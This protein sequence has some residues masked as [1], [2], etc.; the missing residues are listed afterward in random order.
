MGVYNIMPSVWSDSIFVLSGRAIHRIHAVRRQQVERQ[1]AFALQG[2]D[3]DYPEHF[4]G[5]QTLQRR[6]W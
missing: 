3:Q 4:P 1:K 5:F 6:G 2:N